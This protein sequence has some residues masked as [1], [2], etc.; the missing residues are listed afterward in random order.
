M[1]HHHHS[2]RRGP[3]SGAAAPVASRRSVRR[4][5]AGSALAQLSSPAFLAQLTILA[6]MALATASNL[7]YATCSSRRIRKEIYDLTAAEA[8]SL[9]GGLKTLYSN[10][11][12]KRFTD[13]HVSMNSDAHNTP[14]FTPFHRAMVW[15]FETELL[16]VAPELTGLPYWDATYQAD[17]P[18]SS[19]IFRNDMF[20]A[21]VSGCLTGSFA[22]IPN[23]ASGLS[24]CVRRDPRPNFT[25]YSSTLL[26]NSL[27]SETSYS[28]FESTLEY[29]EHASVHNYV[30]G[31]MGNVLYSPS[32]PVFWAHHCAVDYYWTRWQALN[33]G[34][35]GNKY[36]GTHKNRAVS[37]RDVIMNQTVADIL[38]YANTLCYEYQPPQNAP[39]G[40][41][42]FP[43][44]GSSDNSPGKKVSDSLETVSADGPPRSPRARAVFAPSPLTPDFVTEFG[45]DRDGVDRVHQRAAATAK[46][47]QD[48]IASGIEVP[49]MEDLARLAM[50][51][52]PLVQAGNEKPP[53]NSAAA[54]GVGLQ[55]VGVVMTLLVAIALSLSA[56]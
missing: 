8:A 20:G 5:R 12:A 1:A 50:G 51:D 22:G 46:L 53:K 28:S 15:Q 43:V 56:F 10:G 34:A 42:P 16:K 17:D 27:T 54:R 13:M 18:G 47:L 2:T 25:L 44:G 30:S 39:A 4:P 14:Q 38:D 11:V 23:T 33:N 24:G 7:A 31:N 9:V 6:V 35:N 52:G 41:E 36:D 37:T 49:S 45:F 32:D 19:F 3:L 55:L 21:A 26:A 40:K 48:Q 29:G